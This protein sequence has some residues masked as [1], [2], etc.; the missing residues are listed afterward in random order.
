MNPCEQLNQK[1]ENNLPETSKKKSYEKVVTANTY[2]AL[3]IA[4]S[5]LRFQLY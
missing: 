3:G 5:V 2:Q 4:S 1:S